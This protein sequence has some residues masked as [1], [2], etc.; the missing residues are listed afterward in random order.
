[1]AA[2]ATSY[3]R[4]RAPVGDSLYY[5][6]VGFTKVDRKRQYGPYSAVVS[7]DGGTP[8]TTSS[9]STSTTSTSTSTSTST[10][11]TTVPSG[12]GGSFQWQLA[13]IG[14]E[15]ADAVRAIAAP[16]AAGRVAA[17]P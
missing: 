14:G 4:K 6:V 3:A 9:T 5:R 16:P 17:G 11:T 2:N 13:A 15:R 12:S 7:P 1:V 8:P 10:T